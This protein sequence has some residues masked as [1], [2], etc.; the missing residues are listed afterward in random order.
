MKLRITWPENE[1]WT[2]EFSVLYLS[3]SPLEANGAA[4]YDFVNTSWSI[5]SVV[6]YPI[7]VLIVVL[8]P[9]KFYSVFV[10][11]EYIGRPVETGKRHGEGG[12]KRAQ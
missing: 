12:G 7:L 2:V 4:V 5:E 1:R 3:M 11:Y 10:S 6:A 8:L 9:L